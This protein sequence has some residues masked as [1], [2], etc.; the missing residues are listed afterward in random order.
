MRIAL[1]PARGGSKRIIRKNI[2]PFCGKPIIA[3]S[4]EAAFNSN[5]IDRVV[6]STDDEEIAEVAKS[7]G[8]EIPFMRPIELSGDH[9]PTVPVVKH[10]IEWIKSNMGEVNSA[11]C[12]Y[13]TAPLISSND[14]RDGYEKLVSEHV[15]GYVFSGTEM[16]FPIQRSFRVK[17][18]GSCEMFYP[19]H[20]NTRSQ[21]LEKSYQDAGQFYWGYAE[22]FLDEKEFL[23]SDSKVFLLPKHRV[24]DIDSND[25]WIQAEYKWR[26]MQDTTSMDS[27]TD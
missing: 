12:I 4:I 10:A 8:A 11:C 23:S 22:A 1:I 19:E 17:T 2:K 14:I 21:D 15:T 7:F 9:T 25:D 5:V 16:S 3:Y 27:N 20:Y 6:V 18:D 13:A 26:M 24:Q